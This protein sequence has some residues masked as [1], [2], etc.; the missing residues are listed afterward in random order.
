ML[1]CYHRQNRVMGFEVCLFFFQS[2]L[3]ISGSI[4]DSAFMVACLGAFDAINAPITFGYEFN[5]INLRDSANFLFRG[6]ACAFNCSMVISR[7][8]RS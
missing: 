3:N 7:L 1:L 6:H 4:A 5:T 8:F 2:W